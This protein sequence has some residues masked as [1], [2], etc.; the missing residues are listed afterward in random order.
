MGLT[1]RKMVVGA[2]SAGLLSLSRPD[3]IS[4]MSHA[5][6]SHIQKLTPE[7]FS[8]G[9]ALVPDD[10][11]AQ[12][13]VIDAMAAFVVEGK[14]IV[15]AYE[16]AQDEE[17]RKVMMSEAKKQLMRNMFQIGKRRCEQLTA[18]CQDVNKFRTFYKLPVLER[19]VL[20][21]KHKALADFSDIEFV[22]GVE[23]LEIISRLNY[24]REELVANS[25]SSS[26]EDLIPT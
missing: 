6:E 11:Q 14:S 16:R 21:L 2:V 23:R 7:L 9:V 4:R 8:F 26:Q 10:L 17:M 24:A 20:F 12:Q 22:T 18:L 19:A 3:R 1:Y 25:G 5:F 15:V 13:I